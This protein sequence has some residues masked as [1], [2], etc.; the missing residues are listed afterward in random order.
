MITPE[1]LKNLEVVF[2]MARQ[3]SVNNEKQLLDL[4]QFKQLLFKKLEDGSKDNS[5]TEAVESKG[6]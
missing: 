6:E 5:V 3:T 2:A 1:D 4:I